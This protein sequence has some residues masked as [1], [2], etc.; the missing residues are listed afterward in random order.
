ML[1]CDNI[2]IRI[3]FLKKKKNIRLILQQQKKEHRSKNANKIILNFFDAKFFLREKN[4]IFFLRHFFIY[5]HLR[6]Y[7]CSLFYKV[8]RTL[9][10]GVLFNSL[11]FCNYV[12]DTH[13]RICGFS[14]QNSFTIF[15][16][17]SQRVVAK[18]WHDS[19]TIE[20]KIRFGA[21][22][23]SGLE[24]GLIRYQ[25][26]AERNVGRA[27][28]RWI[29]IIRPTQPPHLVRNSRPCKRH[30]LFMGQIITQPLYAPVKWQNS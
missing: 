24:R 26:Q 7:N 3:Y 16:P 1:D 29:F 22:S 10:D 12:L 2:P 25:M 14:K 21:I 11:V 6:L 17:P 27:K 4:Y 15:H 8:L 20:R 18:R 23:G 30:E 5:F 28:L 13:T 9:L 19:S